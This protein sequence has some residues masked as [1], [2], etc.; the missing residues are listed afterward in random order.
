MF[1]VIISSLLNPKEKGSKA[2][3]PLKLLALLFLAVIFSVLRVGGIIFKLE[4]NGFSDKSVLPIV[5]SIIN[6][7]QAQECFGD[8]D[9]FCY[10]C[11]DCSTPAPEPSCCTCDTNVASCENCDCQCGCSVGCGCEC[12]C[13]D[14][15][16][17]CDCIG[18][19]S[20]PTVEVRAE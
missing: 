2:A 15:G 3:F 6:T 13:F 4:K 12:A 18:D 16:F 10:S 11:S 14:C 20:A 8:C 9:C 5:V 7:A 17:S 1:P 19:C